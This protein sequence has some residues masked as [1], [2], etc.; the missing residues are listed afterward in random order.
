MFGG[1]LL[2]GIGSESMFIIISAFIS[3]WF[4]G[5]ELCLSLGII[6]AA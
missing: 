4:M 6:S 2:F 5:K 3:N 1:L